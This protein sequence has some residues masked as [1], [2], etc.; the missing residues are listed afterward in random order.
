MK[1]NILLIVQNNSFPFDKRV[2]REAVTLQKA[3]HNVFVICP[4]SN[5][6]RQIKV[7]EN[8]IFVRRYTDYVAKGGVWGYIF[9]YLNSTIKIHS[10]SIFTILRR[11]ISIVH[12]AN[13]P[14]FFWPLALVTKLLRVR[15]IYDQHDLAPEMSFVKFKNSFIRKILFINEK[16]T[17]KF[18]DAIIVANTAFKDRLRE[19]WGINDNKS[20]VVYN[21]PP[22]DFLPKQNNELIEKY[23]NKKVVLY[24]GLMTVNDNIEVIINTANNL[25]N[26]QNHTDL[27]FVLVGDG[28]VRNKME[29]L[30]KKYS[31][32]EYIDFVGIVNHESVKEFIS[33]S[34]V[35]IAPDKPNGL[36]EFLTLVKIL[37]YMKCSKAFVAFKLKETMEI[38]KEAG[39]YA[40]DDDDFAKKILYLIE[41]K[42]IENEKGVLGNKIIHKNFLWA[43]SAEKLLNL[44]EKL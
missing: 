18:A 12:V 6:D 30:S 34:D 26:S 15:F 10:L 1:K 42:D 7:I 27:K 11:K 22:T 44:Y 21:G 28:D 25:I 14:D 41:N 39:L 23:K 24:V 38:A 31:L 5:H 35:C 16:L 36:N 3:G 13:P 43:H 9:E 20:T 33:I 8:G 32:E 29:N 37:E 40:D 19:K 4:R 17:V 2:Y